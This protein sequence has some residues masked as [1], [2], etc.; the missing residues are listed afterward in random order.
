MRM[1]QE[2]LR[3]E[4]EDAV[5]E[6]EEEEEAEEGLEVEVVVDEDGDSDIN[7]LFNLI[8]VLKQYGFVW[9]HSEG[10]FVFYFKFP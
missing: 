10:T 8:E 2:L 5:E 7:K 6:V 1:L 3:P 4:A 9:F